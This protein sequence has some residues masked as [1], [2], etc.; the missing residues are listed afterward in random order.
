LL[1]TRDDYRHIVFTDA[2]QGA[3]HAVNLAPKFGA[4]PDRSRFLGEQQWR[5]T[6]WLFARAGL[7]ACDYRAETL[8]R[9]LP[10]CVR[11]LHVETPAGARDAVE[12]SPAMLQ[13]ALDA[14]LI[15][16][17]GFFRDRPVFAE[18][19]DAVLPMLLGRRSTIR[20]WSAGCSDGAELYSIAILLAE[21]DALDR[22]QLLGSDCRQSAVRAAAGGWYAPQALHGVSRELLSRYFSF[23][24]STG[25]WG[26][27]PSLRLVPRWRAQDV[28]YGPD[29][30][31]FD[32]ILCRN[33]AMY[34]RRESVARLWE[35]LTRALSAGGVLV[36]GKAE[37]P[38]RTGLACVSPCIFRLE[39][40][41]PEGADD[42]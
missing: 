6:R 30:G 29:L 21:M 16:V 33:L 31:R 28:L 4:R 23:D 8:A 15:G 11:A 35:R 5:F 27:R 9:R 39:S 32:L 26:I 20:V 36:L 38:T 2:L 3:R 40:S 41:E 14:M 19:R 17:T 42:A 25:R 18:L 10:A 12:R 13:A 7:N 1:T 24:A 34:L 37:R 22:A